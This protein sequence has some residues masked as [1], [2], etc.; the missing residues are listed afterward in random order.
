MLGGVEVTYSAPR[1]LARRDAK[2]QAL[3]KL[4]QEIA[5]ISKGYLMEV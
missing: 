1:W 5:A 3:Q 4:R 2:Y